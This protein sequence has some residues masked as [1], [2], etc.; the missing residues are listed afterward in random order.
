MHIT[1][2]LRLFCLIAICVGAS[3]RATPLV[4]V[5]LD[6]ATS[7]GV[8]EGWGSSLAWMGK[9][10]GDSE[11]LADVLYTEKTVEFSGQKLPGLR[12]NIVRYNAG[13]SSWNTLADGRRMV[14]SN[15]ILPFR[16]I[17]GFWIDPS[18]RDPASAAWDWS[19]DANQ[20]TL[21]LRA[22]D[23]G[24][25][26]F[27]LFS[28]SPM[29]WMTK[30]DNP[31][32]AADKG[33]NIN[34]ERYEDFAYYLATIA[35]HARDSWGITFT[36][37]APFNEPS[38]D[39]WNENGKQE[40]THISRAEQAKILPLV[41]AAF[42]AQGLQ[43]VML[44][45]SDESLVNQAIATWKSFS[46]ELKAIIDQ[47]NVHGYQKPENARRAEL[48]RITHVEDGKRLWN[49]ENGDN[50]GTGLAMAYNIHQDFFLLHPTSWSYWQPVDGGL[51]GLGGS[52]WGLLDGAMLHGGELRANPKFFVLAQYSR[53]IRPG[54]QIHLGEDPNTVFA[55]D[56][57][58]GKLVIVSLNRADTEQAYAYD[59]S[60]LA[61]S[62]AVTGAWLTH[63]A[64]SVFY[65][66]NASAAQVRG[67][68]IR[69]SAPAQSVQT[70]EVD[71]RAR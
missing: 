20:R 69:I 41:R 52:G 32:G 11:R 25:N 29:W 33:N 43:D 15:T 36:S 47:V 22:R 10:Y 30:N 6:A 48:F 14:E 1:S 58:A 42:D 34:P 9:A 16:Q 19:V 46:P 60:A 50:D 49:S 65:Q 44:T 55:V 63:P 61:Q 24:A 57:A 3:L 64:G 56:A 13:A 66:P 18:N 21:L 68:T 62:A 28:N 38:A 70:L 45:A 40:S 31:S 51:K 17:E 53:H 7:H 71:F 5:R 26:Y 54:M 8:W 2:L 39:W 59:L 35:R 23:R 67:A 37:V 12:F 4:E 27:E